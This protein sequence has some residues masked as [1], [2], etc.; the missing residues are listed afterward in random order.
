MHI[1]FDDTTIIKTCFKKGFLYRQFIDFLKS[2]FIYI[3][4]STFVL[5]DIVLIFIKNFYINLTLFPFNG[6]IQKGLAHNVALTR[7]IT[8]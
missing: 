7:Q 1:L 8:K 2:D 3:M 5:R 4:Q 6:C